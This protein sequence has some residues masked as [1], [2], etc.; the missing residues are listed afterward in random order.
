MVV[1]PARPM[2]PSFAPIEPLIAHCFHKPLLLWEGVTTA[3]SPHD[4]SCCLSQ[5]HDRWPWLLVQP[6]VSE[7]LGRTHGLPCSTLADGCLPLWSSD[8][9]Q[10][11]LEGRALP[12][13]FLVSVSPVLGS[14]SSCRLATQWIASYVLLYG[15]WHLQRWKTLDGDEGVGWN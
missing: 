5:E 10:E 4:V 15:T 1:F 6:C 12:I 13:G 2:A 7:C 9:Y 11:D 3:L 8:W 14:F